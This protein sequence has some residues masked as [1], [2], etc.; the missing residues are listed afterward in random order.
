MSIRP[1]V[2]ITEA[3]DPIG[4]EILRSE[5][6]V[7]ELYARPGET[8][9]Q[10]LPD[11]DGIVVRIAKVTA[12]RIAMAPR[13]RVIGKHGIGV[14]NIDVAAATQHGVIV[15]F[16][17]GSNSEA[18]AE[19]SLLLIL[20]L[21]RK[22]EALTAYVRVGQFNEGRNAAPGFDLLGKT[23][24][25]VGMGRI[26]GRL[27][28]IARS[29]FSM[30][31]IAFDPYA[32]PARAAELGV[33]LVATLDEVLSASDVISVHAPLT[34]ET[35]NI[36]G[37]DQLRKMKTS[38]LL[39]NCARGG[40]VDEAALADELRRGTIGGAGIDVFD[41]EPP[42]ASHPLFG[43]PNAVVTPHIAGASSEALN[44]TARMVAEETLRVLRGEPGRHAINPQA[45]QKA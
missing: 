20:M 29:A 12:E 10:H 43:L 19:H 28:E 31:V 44:A 35:H 4:A 42:P 36:I 9:E 39:V 32:Q 27:A 37:R 41:I 26:G 2:L 11:I 25:L 45:L 15:T 24:G 14:D 16:T 1:R 6:D 21:A 8:I 7:I 18:V 34:A 3:M 38:A 17:P 23:L 40:L 13:L 33:E 30:R 5:A 22:V